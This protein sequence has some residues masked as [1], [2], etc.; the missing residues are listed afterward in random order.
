MI[1]AAPC[2]SALLPVACRTHTH[3]NKREGT[4]T[5]E[6]LR[7]LHR[8][9][10]VLCT[11]T[12]IWKMIGYVCIQPLQQQLYEIPVARVSVPVCTIDH[13]CTSSV[14]DLGG[15]SYPPTAVHPV[16]RR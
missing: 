8:Y 5:R 2:G 12:F 14:F 4:H 15:I 7:V 3:T 9:L 6:V 13:L 16:H 11:V 10:Y 1:H